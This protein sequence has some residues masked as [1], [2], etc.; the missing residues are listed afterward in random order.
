VIVRPIPYGRHHVDEADIA[1]VTAVLRGDWLTQG[2]EVPRF[3][4]AAAALCNARHAVAT[5]NATSAL[6][7]AC[8]ALGV[9]PGDV[10]WTAANTFVAS[11]NCARFCGATVDFVDINPHTWCLDE[12]LL[13]EKLQRTE[14]A[15]MPLPKVVIPVHFA[16]Q[17]CNM[18]RIAALGNKYGFRIIEDAAHAIGGRYHD[19]PI[20][21]CSFSDLVVFSFHP[22]KTIT[23][24]EGG[25]VLTND[26]ALAEHIIRLRSHGITTDAQLL[27]DP[28]PRPWYYEQIELGY[29]YRMTDLQAALGSSQLA[30]LS[31][32]VT[33]RNHL[34]SRYDYAF[35][36]LPVTL[37]ACE[38]DAYSARHLYVIRVDAA[39]QLELYEFLLDRGIRGQLHYLPVPLQPYY[40]QF[41]FEPGDFPHAEAHAREALSLPLYP[42]LSDE[43]QEQVISACVE[44]LGG[45]SDSAHPSS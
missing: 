37:Q 11:A 9:G 21:S 36:E 20:G 35:A 28:A 17:S 25:M 34:A 1:A 27:T 23:T 40:R 8:L 6:H 5:T 16:G 31:Q 2:P 18:Q 14:R 3:E 10:V 24:G 38:K 32:V 29:N 30:K 7:L 33:R 26:P 15:G 41:G 43:D 13:E 19:R 4:E 44:W 42:M 12:V 45:T 22:V 39:R